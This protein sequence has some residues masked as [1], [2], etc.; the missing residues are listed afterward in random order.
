MSNPLQPLKG[1]TAKDRE[2]WDKSYKQAF[3][4]AGFNDDEIDKKYIKYEFERKFGK[5]AVN[6]VKSTAQRV[7]YYNKYNNAS[8][9][10]NND[11]ADN[12][13]VKPDY[14][15]QSKNVSN[16]NQTLFD[17]Q[18]LF[19]ENKLST[20]DNTRTNV[21][22]QAQIDYQK[23]LIGTRYDSDK[24]DVR[25]KE[26]IAQ[27]KT[28]APELSN[29][30]SEMVNDN[31]KY[32]KYQDIDWDYITPEVMHWIDQGRE[33]IA[34][35]VFS[36][37][38]KNIMADN[39]SG[40]SKAL[41][42]T[43]RFAGSVGLMALDLAGMLTAAPEALFKD[44]IYDGL[45]KGDFDL[46]QVGATL[47]FDNSL[48]RFSY[49]LQNKLRE[50]L[51]IYSENENL[52]YDPESVAFMASMVVPNYGLLSATAKAA[53]G[54]GKI[55]KGVNKVMG[56]EKAITK[57]KDEI[58]KITSEHP[59]YTRL[60][61][62]GQNTELNA[63]REGKSVSEAKK[64]AEEAK[65]NF[66]ADIYQ[67]GTVQKRQIQ[68]SSIIEA[69]WEALST[70][71][72][73]QQRYDEARDSQI[74]N[75]TTQAM[76][77]EIELDIDVSPEKQAEWYFKLQ[78]EGYIDK[79]YNR[80]KQNPDSQ[81]YPEQLLRQL[82]EDYVMQEARIRAQVDEYV[83]SKDP[84]FEERKNREANLGGLITEAE[85]YALL[86]LSEGVGGW[87]TKVPGYNT[88][89]GVAAE[90]AIANKSIKNIFNNFRTFNSAQS[91]IM[92]R[93]KLE[94]D[95]LKKAVTPKSV[96]QSAS[97]I[98][99]LVAIET[100]QEVMQELFTSGAEGTGA[101]NA[102][103]FVLSHMSG[104]GDDIVQENYDNMFLSALQH[105][106][107]GRSANDWLHLIK[108]TMFQVG[109]GTPSVSKYFL[110]QKNT[111]KGRYETDRA[112]TW[113]Q[114]E[115]YLPLNS[116]ILQAVTGINKDNTEARTFINVYNNLADDSKKIAR[117]ATSSMNYAARAYNSLED[118][119]EEGYEYSKFAAQL[120][121][122]IFLSQLQGRNKDIKL[123]YYNNLADVNTKRDN[124]TP[125]EFEERR[126]NTLRQLREDSNFN[127]IKNASDE[128]LSN[129]AEKNGKDMLKLIDEMTKKS[130]Q[131]YEM[132]DNNLSWEILYGSLYSTTLK[133]YTQRNVKEAE[134][135][136]QSLS[137]KIVNTKLDKD[138][139]KN[140][141]NESE[142]LALDPIQRQNIVD[143]SEGK[144]KAIV[145]NLLKQLNAAAVE[146]NITGFNAE[147]S[148][149]KIYNM[150]TIITDATRDISNIINDPERFIRNINDKQV[151]SKIYKAY[152]DIVSIVKNNDLNKSD[153]VIKINAI[154]SQLRNQT[155]MHYIQDNN[156]SRLVNMMANGYVNLLM[157]VLQEQLTSSEYDIV[158]TSNKLEAINGRVLEDVIS[159]LTRNANEEVKN[160]YLNLRDKIQASQYAFTDDIIRDM[161]TPD[162]NILLDN[163]LERY[164]E[165]QDASRVSDIDE[166][167]PIDEGEEQTLSD[168][169][170]QEDEKEVINDYKIFVKQK[171]KEIIYNYTT[172]TKET[173]QAIIDEVLAKN[174]DSR[175][176][177]ISEIDRL[178]VEYLNNK[179]L[180]AKDR[181]SI[182]TILRDIS[183]ILS[184]NAAETNVNT[185]SNKRTLASPNQ[186]LNQ[187]PTGNYAWFYNHY[188]I[189]DLLESGKIKKDTKFYALWDDRFVEKSKELFDNTSTFTLSNIGLVAVIEGVI[190]G[191]ESITANNGK[192]YTPIG[193]F[194]AYGKGEHNSKDIIETLMSE[195]IDGVF[196]PSNTTI[197]KLGQ[198][199]IEGHTFTIDKMKES[200][201]YPLYGIKNSAQQLSE[202]RQIFE[203]KLR[204]S[205]VEEDK[206][207][208]TARA[209]DWFISHLRIRKEGGKLPVP[210]VAI[211]R[212]V[213]DEE[214]LI[215][216]QVKNISD[217]EW[218]GESIIDKL[219]N[220]E[221]RVELVS[222]LTGVPI[223]IRFKEALRNIM[224][225]AKTKRGVDNFLKEIDEINQK[226]E[227]KPEVAEEKTRE[228]LQDLNDSFKKALKN[229][230]GNSLYNILSTPKNFEYY[231]TYKGIVDG[232]PTF[233]IGIGF[234]NKFQGIEFIDIQSSNELGLIAR[235]TDENVADALYNLIID[236][237][238]E[239]RKSPNSD[240][241]DFIKWQFN[242]EDVEK[243]NLQDYARKLL[244]DLY[245]M[246]VFT[247]ETETFISKQLEI[248]F[249][250]D[251]I[252]SEKIIPK[253]P[254][255]KEDIPES[256]EPIDTKTPSEKTAEKLQLNKI[257]K[258]NFE[259]GLQAIAE[260]YSWG[261]QNIILNDI[262][263][264]FI[265]LTDS[266][267]LTII[268][269]DNEF[270]DN[271]KDIFISFLLSLNIPP[272][273][274]IKSEKDFNLS[275]ESIK[276]KHDVKEGKD[277]D[278][279]FGEDNVLREGKEIVDLTKEI[280]TKLNS[281]L[282]KNMLREVDETKES[283]LELLR[284]KYKT[285]EAV[286]KILSD[287]S[288]QTEEGIESI[289]NCLK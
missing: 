159:D 172:K 39:Q 100:G 238:G 164:K 149:R 259:E 153:K 242:Y 116:P 20:S 128:E 226:Y 258:E 160:Q 283:I 186:F 157:N 175:S 110:N 9:F 74:R 288:T 56:R 124:E 86:R 51:P 289:I 90:E 284:K 10:I 261:A 287:P 217:T 193:L 117:Y 267:T 215:S 131:M 273:V 192:Q 225:D 266:N 243:Q 222:D 112:Y 36:K 34:S 168:S 72:A 15:V 118:Q 62:E 7:E 152:R 78:N 21:G 8:E 120:A 48:S 50:S 107:Y 52:L 184:R 115:R 166:K 163:I 183:D 31:N 3:V 55:A 254:V 1:L 132:Y 92:S 189:L 260:D 257:N 76:L 126:N 17:N 191:Y 154:T 207:G 245:D 68:A 150:S 2:V 103:Q 102:E 169:D 237:D 262:P 19:V 204:D 63:L 271:T 16:I 202:D 40:I 218:N 145:D 216:I 67:K 171:T 23:Y 208:I 106:G 146:K 265:G 224:S 141:L 91:K 200:K 234:E 194:R 75:L 133:E 14:T 98:G 229:K 119:N 219:K 137:E 241:D 142:I 43:G 82:A 155:F 165:I 53:K 60:T 198:K 96:A 136:L 111:P 69:Q 240:T 148:F 253:N 135:Q 280:D 281:R 286:L 282:W 65:T 139:D 205:Y 255:E 109:V 71:D 61:T 29:Y 66:L 41:N 123:A 279:S 33:D 125:E 83:N 138:T 203:E 162:E 32:L 212:H 147:D 199:I 178:S 46:S 272:N 174:Y 179:D 22:V 49:D 35:Q 105:G 213:D 227:N 197:P 251:D 182:S 196:V 252:K 27:L 228:A 156:D 277:T 173:I 30:Y 130:A 256:A 80:F 26:E 84:D 278:N 129:W 12:N 77:G 59:L 185:T 121:E 214:S 95:K 167:I 81:Q 85:N 250:T 211:P 104:V 4:Q 270:N 97:D 285:D 11:T 143:R 235:L 244:E 220:P 269:P 99:G 70:K 89:S 144:Q 38:L 236:E 24:D 44:V 263:I 158:N 93:I 127:S 47:F 209:K 54:T 264:R 181:R 13:T 134:A 180:K 233:S 57:A 58:D 28:I 275:E 276:D 5:D 201:L 18:D 249:S 268:V 140:I 223:F 239:V 232:V 221:T 176:G 94:G 88:L 248:E 45:I 122:S 246:G 42:W 6:K 231:I 187:H 177:I 79:I 64:L 87:T 25:K 170:Y 195:A 210:Q 73:I 37:Y 114:I 161:L 101:H 247:V 274:V 151:K 230:W 108:S 190:D 113:R 188:K 206:E